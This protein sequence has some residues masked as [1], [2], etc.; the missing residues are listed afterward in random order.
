MAGFLYYVPGVEVVGEDWARLGP[1]AGIIGDFRIEQ[2]A[3]QAGPDGGRGC[4]VTPHPGTKGARA[5]TVHAPDRQRWVACGSY[6]LG[7]ETDSVRPGPE[8]LARPE[9]HGGYE[10]ALSDGGIW[11]VSPV[12]ALPSYFGY[13]EDGSRVRKAKPG[14]EGL[15]AGA[16]V[17][18][19]HFDRAGWTFDSGWLATEEAAD[20][21]IAALV[22]NYRIGPREA[23]E[24]EIPTVADVVSILGALLDLPR[25]AG[26]AATE[27]KKSA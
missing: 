2:T 11:V 14:Y 16:E 20:I 27:E 22:V 24:L 18:F 21:A 12:S 9:L 1:L 5:A 17:A 6:W 4:I 15:S 3:T 19:G 23:A 7:R 25:L 10:A 26:T 8:D 13:E